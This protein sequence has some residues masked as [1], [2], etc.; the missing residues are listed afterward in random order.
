MTTET[1][2]ASEKRCWEI[3]RTRLVTEV[4]RVEADSEDEAF[5]NLSNGDEG[6]DYEKLVE[7]TL[8]SESEIREIS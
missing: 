1:S 4:F 3:T 5:D 7:N 6:G 8:H 2:T